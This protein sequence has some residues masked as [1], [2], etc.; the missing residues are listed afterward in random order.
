MH[1]RLRHGGAAARWCAGSVSRCN[2]AGM[3]EA[4]TAADTAPVFLATNACHSTSYDCMRG[5]LDAARRLGWSCFV[6]DARMQRLR[7]K[8]E[9]ARRDRIWSALARKADLAADRVGSPPSATTGLMHRSKFDC[10]VAGPPLR[11]R[12]GDGR[13]GAKLSR[14][15]RQRD[16]TMPR[17]GS[18]RLCPL[19]SPGGDKENGRCERAWRSCCAWPACPA[20]RHRQAPPVGDREQRRM[21]WSTESMHQ[22]LSATSDQRCPIAVTYAAVDKP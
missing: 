10:L 8:N 6:V 21:H 11:L 17:P 3:N 22:G 5:Y 15:P 14:M 20:S 1:P 16:A 4:P 9:N 19:A 2:R 18:D 12:S 13:I 7:V